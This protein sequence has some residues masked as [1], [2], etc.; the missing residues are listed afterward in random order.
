MHQ[1][2][3]DV[4]V[5]HGAVGGEAVLDVRVAL[6]GNGIERLGRAVPPLDGLV[7]HLVAGV[8]VRPLPSDTSTGELGRLHRTTR[9]AAFT[10]P[11]V[12]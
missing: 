12:T 4:H 9:S 11:P 8:S 5:D 10:A 7:D 3:F 1:A 6:P 2:E